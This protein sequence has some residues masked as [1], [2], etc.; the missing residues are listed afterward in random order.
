MWSQAQVQ[1][2]P[3][4]EPEISHKGAMIIEGEVELLLPPDIP[5]GSYQ[6]QAG[7]AN[8]NGD[9][10]R[11]RLPPAGTFLAVKTLP[12]GPSTP[13]F[14][15]N[16]ELTPQLRLQGYDLSDSELTPGATVW[17]AFHWQADNLPGGDDELTLR[18]L[19]QESQEVAAWS[20]QPVYHTWPADQWPANFYVRD[21]W[22]LTLPSTLAAGQYR[23]VLNF[24]AS[25]VDPKAKLADVYLQDLTIVERKSTFQIPLMQFQA[26]ES[27]SNLATLLGYDLSGTLSDQGAQVAI[28]LYWQ[29]EQ[30]I[31]QPYRVNLRLVDANG[32]VLAEQ[33]S[34]PASG[35]A[36]TTEWQTGE[37]V[38]DQHEFKIAGLPGGP[39]QIE[40]RLLDANGKPAP[41]NSGP[42]ALII[43]AAQEKV[44]WRTAIP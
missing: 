23:L 22:L 11:F 36:P 33:E 40:V 38:A 19:D 6:L 35:V 34:E 5:P 13:A 43:T 12:V 21:P 8:E 14:P 29:A 26:G 42:T 16:T 28:T 9:V 18:L 2:L 32:V 20:K 41:L 3:E 27:F 15:L 39:V 10:G 17:I 1:P 44:N 7:F 30:S 24:N 31:P 37:V 4:F 25:G